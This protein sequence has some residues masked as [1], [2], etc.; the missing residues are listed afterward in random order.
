MDPMASEQLTQTPRTS[1]WYQFLLWLVSVPLPLRKV[2]ITIFLDERR[3]RA[4]A[5]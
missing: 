1:L 4:M 2:A 3:I 5:S